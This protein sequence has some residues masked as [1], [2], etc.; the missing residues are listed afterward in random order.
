MI[1]V[2]LKQIFDTSYEVIFTTFKLPTYLGTLN[3]YETIFTFFGAGFGDLFNISC[4][5]SVGTFHGESC[6]HGRLSQHWS[7][8]FWFRSEHL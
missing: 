1:T 3:T 6:F 7:R 5:Y 4:I 8:S 2:C